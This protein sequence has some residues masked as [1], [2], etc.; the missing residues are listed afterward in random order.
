MHE[1][2]I[3]I[4]LVDLAAAAARGAGAERVEV[5]RLRLGA[6][7]GVVAEALAFGFDVAA[8]GTI[9]A[10][11][12]LEIERLPLIIYCASCASPAEL[13]DTTSF[14]CPRCGRPSAD[15]RQGRELEL[16]SLEVADPAPQPEVPR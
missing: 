8:G 7:S 13:A 14:R 2:S 3:A 6:L 5:V 11:A 16:A 10:G 1:L 4:S 9:V 15:I 12:R